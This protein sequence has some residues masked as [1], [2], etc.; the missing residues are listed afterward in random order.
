MNLALPLISITNELT[1]LISYLKKIAKKESKCCPH[2][3]KTTGFHTIE[4]KNFLS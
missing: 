3:I 2:D 4:L 1:T